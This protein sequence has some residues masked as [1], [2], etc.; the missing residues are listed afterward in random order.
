MKIAFECRIFLILVSNVW[1]YAKLRINA[2]GLHIFRISLF[3]CCWNRVKVKM[4][5]SFCFSVKLLKFI[6]PSSRWILRWNQ[7]LY[8][9]WIH[10]WGWR[11]YNNLFVDNLGFLIPSHNQEFPKTFWIHIPHLLSTT[12]LQSP[13]L[14]HTILKFDPTLCC[15]PTLLSLTI[16]SPHNPLHSLALL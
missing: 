4:L 13:A 10:L 11:R 1:D 6:F 2:P 8:F 14:W 15:T 16:H 3:V 12:F 9:W 5:F 7:W